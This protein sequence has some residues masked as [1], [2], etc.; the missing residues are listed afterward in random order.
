MMSNSIRAI[1][2]LI[3]AGVVSGCAAIGETDF[4]CGRPTK[5]VGC[6]PA[7]EV[8]EIT[9]DPELYEE[10]MK[11]LEAAA[12]SDEEYNPYDIV[13]AVKARHEP[14]VAVAKS[15]AEPISQPLPVLKP[16]QVIRI[17]FD[18]WVDQ[19]G[20]LHMPGYVFTE[21]TPRRWSFGEPEVSNSEILAPIQVDRG[22]GG[23]TN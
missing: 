4:S 13:A 23:S 1:A 18:A 22:S 21:I 19:K 20:D 17:W 9:N 3:M 7:T 14:T 12:Q 6:L 2:L 5:G 8:Y 11:E 10:V 16:A 15:M